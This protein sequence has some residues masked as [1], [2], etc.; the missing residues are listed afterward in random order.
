MLFSYFIFRIS[1]YYLNICS[2]LFN[3]CS[4]I[5]ELVYPKCRVSLFIMLSQFKKM[6]EMALQ[7]LE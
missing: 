5:V 6:L 2:I 1:T 4:K 7:E 3:I